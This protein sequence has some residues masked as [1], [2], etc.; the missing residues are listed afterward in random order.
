MV[1]EGYICIE[2]KTFIDILILVS[3]SFSS[4][5]VAVTMVPPEES[6]CFLTKWDETVHYN[7]FLQF[8]KYSYCACIIRWIWTSFTKTIQKVYISFTHI[9]YALCI[10]IDLIPS[11]SFFMA[12]GLRPAVHFSYQLVGWQN[13]DDHIYVY[14]YIH[15]YTCIYRHNVCIISNVFI[16]RNAGRLGPASSV[17]LQTRRVSRTWWALSVG[18]ESALNAF[19]IILGS[20]RI[21]IAS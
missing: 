7:I 17:F 5:F 19:L 10:F 18:C 16:G 15:A 8:Y 11:L 6:T 14:I 1:W 3:L 12:L 20:G 4:C 2:S 9:I 21:S 13:L